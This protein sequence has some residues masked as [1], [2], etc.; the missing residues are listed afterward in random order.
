VGTCEGGGAGGDGGVDGDSKRARVSDSTGRGNEGA[1][2]RESRQVARG[3][4]V[5]VAR[6][7]VV[8]V[9]RVP[10][11]EEGERWWQHRQ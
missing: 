11:Q 4:M 6:G 5:E 7:H 9:V 1:R 10:G 3:C 8:E 2:E